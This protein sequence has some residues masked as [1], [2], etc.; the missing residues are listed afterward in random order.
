MERELKRAYYDVHNPTAFTSKS[1][2]IKKFKGKYGLDEISDWAAR[3]DNITRHAGRQTRFRRLPTLAH[4]RNEIWHLDTC[5]MRKYS[6]AN[7][8]VNYFV[9]CVDVLS[10]YLHVFAMKDKTT[11]SVIKGMR[12][13]FAKERP[14]LAV[15]TDIGGEYSSRKFKSFLKE[16]GI[17]LWNAYNTETKA[18]LA[19]ARIKLLKSRLIKYMSHHATE[20]WTDVLDQLCAAVNKSY[21]RNIGM[22]PADV[23]G[24]EQEKK[25]FVKLYGSRLGHPTKEASTKVGDTVRISRLRKQFEHAYFS[26]Y[27]DEKFLVKRIYP[28]GTHNLIEVEDENDEILHGKFYEK[29]VIAAKK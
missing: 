15:Y 22:A 12:K 25:V 28:R 26:G 24:K 3:Q 14:R 21:S 7:R 18:T 10:R 11:D 6:K 2:L 17:E 8:N 1:N 5:D 16:Y 13:I 29:E 4:G 19:E 9:V 27:S 20:R 23:K